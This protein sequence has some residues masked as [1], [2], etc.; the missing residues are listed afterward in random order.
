MRKLI[1]KTFLLG[2]KKY[3]ASLEVSSKTLPST[4][5]R[6]I[7]TTPGI[8]RG[9]M[10]EV[11]I[12]KVNEIIKLRNGTFRPISPEERAEVLDKLPSKVTFSSDIQ[13]DLR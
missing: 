12:T 11:E 7:K 3:I 9:F 5:A 2:K 6:I 8:L 10:K 1:T 4:K 13:E